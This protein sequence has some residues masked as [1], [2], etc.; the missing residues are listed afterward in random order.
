MKGL[1]SF[2]VL[3]RGE[4]LTL[5]LLH[6]QL[7]SVEVYV[8]ICSEI[9]TA[10]PSRVRSTIEYF[11]RTFLSHLSLGAR[12]YLRVGMYYV[13]KKVANLAVAIL[14]FLLTIQ[15]LDSYQHRQGFIQEFG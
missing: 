4:I 5:L 8:S 2:A 9:C 1:Q 13:L 11:Y 14:G 6:F 7:V 15:Q 3:A 12:S 10:S